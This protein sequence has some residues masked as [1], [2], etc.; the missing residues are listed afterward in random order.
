MFAAKLVVGRLFT[1]DQNVVM[2]M[3]TD[4]IPRGSIWQQEFKADIETTSK[5]NGLK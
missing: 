4:A 2:A 1:L 3:E 5:A